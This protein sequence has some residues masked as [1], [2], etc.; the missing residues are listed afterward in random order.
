[1]LQDSVKNINSD[2]MNLLRV[3]YFY[4]FFKNTKL[5]I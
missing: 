4:Q 3:N 1:M 2:G 5:F